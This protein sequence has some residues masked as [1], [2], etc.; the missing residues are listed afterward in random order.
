[1][2]ELTF[3]TAFMLYLSFTFLAVMGIWLF[4]HFRARHKTILTC[5]KELIICEFCRFAYLEQ[6]HKPLNK[7]PQCGLFNRRL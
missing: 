3:N 5:E 1:M 2:I 7:C 4:S 6:Q